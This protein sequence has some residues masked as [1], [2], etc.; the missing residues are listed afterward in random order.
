MLKH[1]QSFA[2]ALCLAA[3]G[4]DTAMPGDTT[5]TTD[6]AVETTDTAPET[7]LDSA[8]EA[9]ETD[10][11]PNPTI[12]AELGEHCAIEDRIGV[13]QLED[14]GVGLYLGAM[15]EDR[16]NPW[17]GAPE[18]TSEA[19]AFYR[20]KPTAACPPC[21]DDEL[22]D[23]TGTCTKA[24]APYPDGRV[25]LIAGDARQT[26]DASP[27]TREVGGP[28]TLPG[29]T[30]ALEIA[31]GGVLINVPALTAPG[32][33]EDV[34]GTLE[35]GYDAPTRLDVAWSTK[36]IGTHVFTHIPINH[37][38]AA[39]TFTRCSVPATDGDFTVGEAMLTP[40]AV[41]TGLE[42]QGLE[43]VRF[44]AAETPMGCVEVRFL[45]R[46]YVNLF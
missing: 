11:S 8:P 30:F 20:F 5:D 16:R 37:H 42:F 18:L 13:V 7:L 4:S 23:R 29:E 9:A 26:F 2:L 33:L 6:D 27:E 34:V 41:S 28:V 22:C 3:C 12:I 38:A 19:C 1:P 21:A 10:T 24:P 43:H 32:D 35:G 25:V 17:Y 31:F 46:Y 44:A 40:L 45:E 15:L 36:D 39:P 14:T